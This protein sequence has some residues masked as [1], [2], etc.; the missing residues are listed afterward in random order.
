MP[1]IINS[2]TTGSGGL[3]STGDAST[4]LKLQTA[5]TDAVTIDGSQN[6]T[7]AQDLSVAGDASVTG[8]LTVTGTV[9]DAGAGYVMQ[10]YTSPATWT[11]P[12]GLKAVKVTV[13]GGGGAS[14]TATPAPTIP[15]NPVTSGGTS[16][17]GSFLS[18]TG[19]GLSSPNVP[20]SAGAGGSGS[21]GDINVSGQPG[22]DVPSAS[23]SVGGN[24]ALG[25][26]QG[27]I[28]S[29]VG[30]S[31]IAYGGGAHANSVSGGAGGGG[32]SIEFISAPSIP[33]PV[34]VTVGAGGT[35]SGPTAPNGG[36][37]GAGIVIV[38]EF[39]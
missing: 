19:G 7:L 6:V 15:T 24:S 20:V 33:G 37:G 11:K 38:E 35:I 29:E 16:S 28:I 3:I 31:G 1:S 13:V 21:G 27:A 5:D 17:F 8:N 39:Y 25:F 12:A 34:S 9:T 23:C 14:R 36:N 30:A 4:T 10:T 32:A 2:T 18:A 22:R 26:G